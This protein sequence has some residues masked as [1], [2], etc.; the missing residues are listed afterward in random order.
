MTTWNK[1]FCLFID[2]DAPEGATCLLDGLNSTSRQESAYFLQGDK[3]TL[4][5]YFRRRATSSLNASSAI[6]LPSDLSMIF[7]AKETANLDAKTLLF[8]ATDFVLM[9]AEDDLYYSA[10]LDL[11][12]PEIAAL[13]A[14]LSSTSAAVRIDIQIQNAD[15]TERS[16]FQFDAVL[17]QQVYAGEPNPQ[18]GTPVYPLPQQL[19]LKQADGSWVRFTG[20]EQNLCIYEPTT[21]KFYPL[22]CKIVDGIVVFAPGEG[23]DP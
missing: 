21:N 12:T 2:A 17:K 13:F 7:A 4:K 5:L 3:F 20:T 1:E 15:N 6:M 11:N 8:S 22:V 23:V 19:V 16:T 14:R 18:S 10:L 9:G